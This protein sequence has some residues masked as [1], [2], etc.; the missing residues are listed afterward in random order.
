MRFSHTI[1]LGGTM[2]ASHAVSYAVR[3]DIFRAFQAAPKEPSNIHFGAIDA[4]VSATVEVPVVAPAAVV[5]AAVVPAPAPLV[6]QAIVEQVDEIDE[7]AQQM[8]VLDDAD[9]VAVDLAPVESVA[10][11]APAARGSFSWAA[12]ASKKQAGN[13][14]PAAAEGAAASKRSTRRTAAPKK[15]ASTGAAATKQAAATSSNG[16]SKGPAPAKQSKAAPAAAPAATGAAAGA[17]GN[18]KSGSSSRQRASPAARRPR[19]VAAGSVRVVGDL[20]KASPDQVQAAFAK[21]GR[22]VT[23]SSSTLSKG[24]CFVDFETAEA[25]KAAAGAG[26]VKVAGEDVSVEVNI[27]FDAGRQRPS[28]GKGGVSRR[29]GAQKP[30]QRPAAATNGTSQ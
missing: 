19:P 12:V 14:A 9:Q 21:F 26:T 2:S 8:D 18:S 7:P 1:L 20:S 6:P 4:V 25:V 11:P 27:K 15:V 13:A 28:S 17:A 16:A 10:V 5:P 3:A 29:A 30:R 23:M 22:V 24:F